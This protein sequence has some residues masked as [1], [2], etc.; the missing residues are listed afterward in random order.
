MAKE[1][2]TKGKDKAKG[3][4][5]A[6]TKDKPDAKVE[7][8]QV[9][10]QAVEATEVEKPTEP[11]QPTVKFGGRRKAVKVKDTATGVVYASKS[12][13]GKAVAAELGLDPDNA[14]VWYQVVKQAPGRFEE[15]VE[16]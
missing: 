3:K 16:G 2:G 10:D 6:D 4:V 11:E 13:A 7:E 15:V 5:K 9:S 1:K 8:T 12:K 14:F